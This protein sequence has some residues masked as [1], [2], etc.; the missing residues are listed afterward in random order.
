MSIQTLLMLAN[1]SRHKLPVISD[2]VR[3]W[4]KNPLVLHFFVSE[5]NFL[6][7]LF[8]QSYIVS[9]LPCDLNLNLSCIPVSPVSPVWPVPVCGLHRAFVGAS[10]RRNLMGLQPA[11]P[12]CHQKGAVWQQHW[13]A[14]G[15]MSSGHHSLRQSPLTRQ[16]YGLYWAVAWTVKCV[17]FYFVSCRFTVIAESLSPCVSHLCRRYGGR[18]CSLSFVTGRELPLTTA[19][20]WPLSKVEAFPSFPNLKTLMSSA[21]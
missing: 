9:L 16:K 7:L 11:P 21:F 3:L 10:L 4:Q 8:N 2:E 20:C 12:L 18:S 17:T 15:P 19:S 5:F 1:I 14:A 13:K 6:R